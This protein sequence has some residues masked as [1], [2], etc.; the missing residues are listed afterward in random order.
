MIKFNSPSVTGKEIHYIKD[1]ID[2]K[3]LS[4]NNYYT[5]ECQ[6][7]LE[8]RYNVPKVLLTTSCTDALEMSALLI[9]IEK[10][11]EIIMP[12]YTFVSTANA[13]VLRGASLKFIDSLPNHPN[14]D[15]GLIEQS[16][17]PKTKAIVVVHYAGV[18]V[19]MEA[20]LEIAKRHNLYVIEDAAQA[21]ESDY[22]FKDGTKKQLGT[23]GDFGTFSFHETKNI[24]SGE[25]GA[26][27]INNNKFSERAEIIWEKGT[28]RASFYRGEINKYGWVDVGSS[29]LPSELN[30]AYLFAQLEHIDEIAEKRKEVHNWYTH[31]VKEFSLQTKFLFPADLPRSSNNGHIFYLICT[32]KEE[33]T[34]LISYLSSHNIKAVFHYIALHNSEFFL[35][36]SHEPLNLVNSMRYENCLLRL[37]M[38]NSL[39]K[40]D[41]ESICLVLNNFGKK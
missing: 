31:F 30:A 27:L 41:V 35:K 9:D 18:S 22:Q 37:P 20:V 4:G 32:S 39:T 23:I 6:F 25:G 29:F 26:L 17:S 33:R 15:V 14:I 19:D 2:K 21:I 11:D 10:G 36:E 40:E 8:N 13:F 34:K 5:K 1:A 28:N 24:T 7:F 3:Q 38:H 16:I 12:S